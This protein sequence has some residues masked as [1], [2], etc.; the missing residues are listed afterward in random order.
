MYF[1]LVLTSYNIKVVV[2]KVPLQELDEKCY[3]VMDAVDRYVHLPHDGYKEA[4]T[5][6]LYEFVN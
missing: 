4:P 1:T 5:T 2:F 3:T 6:A